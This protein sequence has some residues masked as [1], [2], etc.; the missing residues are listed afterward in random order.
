[1]CILTAYGVIAKGLGY[2][3]LQLLPQNV[4]EAFKVRLLS[5]RLI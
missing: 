3:P 2:G 4:K 5:L 1:M